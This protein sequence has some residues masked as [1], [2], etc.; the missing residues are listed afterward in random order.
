MLYLW[1]LD[2]EHTGIISMCLNSLLH[3]V[4]L[5]VPL[6]SCYRGFVHVIRYNH[7]N[8]VDFFG[9]SDRPQASR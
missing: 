2:H 8:A 9:I 7:P 5:Y 4:E 3:P 6:Y 1:M